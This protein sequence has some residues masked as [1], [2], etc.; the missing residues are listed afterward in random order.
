MKTANRRSGCRRVGVAQRSAGVWACACVMS[1]SSASGQH[2]G[3]GAHA[4]LP[5]EKLVFHCRAG[6]PGPGLSIDVP[7]A[8]PAADA[9]ATLDQSI[10]LPQPYQPVKLVR[11]LPRAELQQKAAAVPENNGA[12]AVQLT[13]AGPTQSF[14]RWLVADDQER[15]RLIS[16]IATW[17]FM[18]VAGVAGRNALN[19]QYRS[20]F[21]REPIMAVSTLDGSNRVER[22]LRIGETQRLE[23]LGCKLKVLEFFTDY[24]VD[25]STK[26]AINRSPRRRNPAVLV[27]IDYKRV[28]E[29]RLIFAKFPE[30]WLHDNDRHPFRVI[31]DCPVEPDPRVPDYL[32]IA[33]DERLSELWIRYEDE[34]EVRN[35]VPDYLFGVKGSQYKWNVSGFVPSARIEESFI[36]AEGKGDGAALRLEYADAGGERSTHWLEMGKFRTLSTSA[37]PLVVWFGPEKSGEAGAHP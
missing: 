25:G 23:E 32:L 15:N 19:S 22:P 11:Y 26:A 17:R 28:P 10:E 16:F 33:I 6:Q 29:Q 12:P 2:G 13:V 8:L 31:L 21:K 35:L 24:G 14:T 34:I 37:G 20:E 36:P 5:G 4:P 18:N 27:E 30:F 9:E 7:V 3:H 1:A